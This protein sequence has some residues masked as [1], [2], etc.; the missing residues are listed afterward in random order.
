MYMITAP[1]AEDLVAMI[2]PYREKYDPL[3][4]AMP[5]HIS[6]LKPFE[7]S[8]PLE[9]LYEHLEEIGETYSPIKVSIVGW[10]VAEQAGYQLRLPLIAGRQEFTTLRQTLLAEPLSHAANPNDAYWPHIVFGRFTDQAAVEAV[11]ESLKGFEPKFVFRVNHIELLERDHQTATW[12]LN[13][14]YGLNA[15]A[16]GK[17]RKK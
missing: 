12:Q 3:F 5:P 6:I 4:Q 7:F 14:K 11:K 9:Q 1:I 15:T 8:N 13:H 16:A 2:A 17:R 10:D